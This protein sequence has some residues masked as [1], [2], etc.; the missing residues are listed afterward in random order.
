MATQ[1][2]ADATRYLT[3]PAYG[4]AA[5][6]VVLPI[7]DTIA[8]V[9]PVAL[10]N[11]AWRYGTIGLGANYLISVLFGMLGLG[12]LAALGSHRRTL[13]ALAIAS[14]IAA[15]L[16]LIATLAFLLDALQLR[17]AV[18]RDPPRTLWMFDVGAAKAAFKYVVSAAAIGWLALATWRAGRAIPRP[19]ADEIVPKLVHEQKGG[20]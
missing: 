18:P 7:I 6:F 3:G 8:Q 11:P 2:T 9:W 16:L 10:G 13:R 14:G 17:A 4:I 19:A 20:E 5:L 15:L 12:L 1:R